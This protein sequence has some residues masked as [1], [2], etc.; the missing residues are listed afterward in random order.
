LNT[1]HHLLDS[2]HFIA[3]FLAVWEFVSGLASTSLMGKRTF[4]VHKTC[5][6]I[7]ISLRL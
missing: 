2:T 4:G 5:A 1:L 6:C 7:N 3:D